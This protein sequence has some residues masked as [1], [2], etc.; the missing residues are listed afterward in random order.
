LGG[1]IENKNWWGCY[2][3]YHIGIMTNLLLKNISTIMTKMVGNIVIPAP[4]FT[5]HRAIP[6]KLGEGGTLSNVLRG[7]R[8][9]RR[10]STI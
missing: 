3:I 1:E 10:C 4:G 6:L 2:G 7:A 9:P 5:I 8:T